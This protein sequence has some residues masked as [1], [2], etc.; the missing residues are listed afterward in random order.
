[1]LHDAKGPLQAL[2]GPRLD[3]QGI[4]SDT[5]LAAYLVRPDQRS[6]DLADLVLRNL[7]RELRADDDSGGPGHARLL[8]DGDAAARDA[9]VRARAVLDLAGVARQQ[10][11]ATGGAELLSRDRAARSSRPRPHGAA[12]ASPPTSRR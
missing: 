9:M 5:A 10:L 1:M 6:Y 2:R 3:L 12:P 4:T 11:E 8:A 7:R